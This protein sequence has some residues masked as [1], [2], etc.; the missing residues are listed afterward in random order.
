MAAAHYRCDDIDCYCI[1]HLVDYKQVCIIQSIRYVPTIA[2]HASF[3]PLIS[4][5]LAADVA[6]EQGLDY[7]GTQSLKGEYIFVSTN[8][9]N[10]GGLIG[11][12][13]TVPFAKH[14]VR[15][16]TGLVIFN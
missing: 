14:L 2:L 9:F 4:N 7:H 5:F 8:A 12:F 6:E 13:L 15:L 11:T 16:S 10:V 3:L 1:D